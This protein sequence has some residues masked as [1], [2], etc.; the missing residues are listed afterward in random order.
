MKAGFQVFVSLACA[1]SAGTWATNC[2]K[3][4]LNTALNA[5]WHRGDFT[6][7]EDEYCGQDGK[8]SYSY[9]STFGVDFESLVEKQRHTFKRIHILDLFGSAVFIHPRGIDSL[10]G[11][12]IAPLAVSAYPAGFPAQNHSEVIGN[13]FSRK[14]WDALRSHMTAREI[15]LFTL[16]TVRPV[17]GYT[18]N[19]PAD[20]WLCI[21]TIQ[22]ALDLLESG[23][24]LYASFIE[25]TP[26]DSLSHFLRWVHSNDPEISGVLITLSTELGNP[27]VPVLHFHKLKPGN[28]P[29]FSFAEVLKT[30]GAKR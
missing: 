1:W 22:R 24:D 30:P 23:G 16:I 11:V 10:V 18:L 28:L 5:P 7:D 19:S 8:R 14:T 4:V 21:Q 13:V 29:K 3:A 25:T 26:F 12:R 6:T 20:I 2:K 15:R 17:G 27:L 9:G